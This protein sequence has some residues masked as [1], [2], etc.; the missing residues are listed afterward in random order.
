MISSR[1]ILITNDD[2]IHATG[3]TAL[4]NRLSAEGVSHA[5]AAPLHEKS[6]CGHSITLHDPLR[7]RKLADHRFAVHGTPADAVI[8]YFDAPLHQKPDLVISGINLGGN[9]AHDLTY[10]GTVCAAIEGFYHGVTSIAV[11]LYFGKGSQAT[12]A[13]DPYFKAAADLFVGKILPFMEAA[14]GGRDLYETPRLFNVNIPVSAFKKKRPV[15]RW[16]S[17]GKRNYGGQII[18]R[19]DPRGRPYY[20]IGGDQLGFEDIPGS[21]CNA[22]RD[23]EVSIT[24]LT[25]HFT[26]EKT[27]NRLRKKT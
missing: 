12:C 7:A 2:G 10:S 27:L 5:V 21:D 3:I 23:G 6:G 24:P 20:W 13:P 9:L 26:D 25:T 19:E 15:I 1:F 16:T 22:M 14:C 8:L 17:L 11:S 18:K 4:E